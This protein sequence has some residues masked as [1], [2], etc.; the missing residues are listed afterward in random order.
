[1]K[2]AL[3]KSQ[4]NV[5]SIHKFSD[6]MYEFPFQFSQETFRNQTMFFLRL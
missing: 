3:L 2:F 1:M 6:M 5:T 4:F